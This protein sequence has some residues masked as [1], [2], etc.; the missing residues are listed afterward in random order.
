M[1][2]WSQYVLVI[3][4]IFRLDFNELSEYWSILYWLNHDCCY[5]SAIL[6][7]AVCGQLM[8]VALLWIPGLVPGS[9]INIEL[10]NLD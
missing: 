10:S 5:H 1:S 6:T 8:I 4:S 9:S 7:T 3:L 2:C